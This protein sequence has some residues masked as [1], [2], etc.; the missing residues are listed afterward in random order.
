MNDVLDSGCAE[1]FCVS[2]TLSQ[3][4]TWCLWLVQRNC[5]TSATLSFDRSFTVNPF[6]FSFFVRTVCACLYRY[7]LK[8]WA[9]KIT[10]GSSST[11]RL[12]DTPCV[13]L[14]SRIFSIIF[15]RR[16]PTPDVFLL[17]RRCC[18]TCRV[19]FFL[20]QSPRVEPDSACFRLLRTF[21]IK[22]RL[23]YAHLL[24]FA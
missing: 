17:H 23:G 9:G 19:L 20:C 21:G 5:L 13:C 1:L 4:R 8:P 11:R 7:V 3:E 24:C 22:T 16:W 6:S 18:C 12:R 10:I 15:W 2:C 14:D